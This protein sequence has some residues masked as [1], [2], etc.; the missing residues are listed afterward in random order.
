MKRFLPIAV[1]LLA[2]PFVAAAC[3][4]DEPAI[5]DGTVTGDADS[6]IYDEEY[7]L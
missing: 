4:D 5:E 7:G 2:A 3:D 6:T 1:V